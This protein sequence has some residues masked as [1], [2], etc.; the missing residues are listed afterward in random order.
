VRGRGGQLAS[1]AMVRLV[2]SG[3]DVSG[4]QKVLTGEVVIRCH[5]G[6]S[7]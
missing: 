5:V 3:D 4:R 6:A 2:V 1:G 7:G